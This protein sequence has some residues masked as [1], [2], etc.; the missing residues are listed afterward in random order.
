MARAGALTDLDHALRGRLPPTLAEQVRL[1]NVRDGRIV[2]V[3]SSA[4]WAA[5]LRMEQATLL[6]LARTLGV[7]ARGVTIRIAPLPAAPPEPAAGPALSAAAARHLRAA[8]AASRDPQ[9][10]AQLLAMASLATS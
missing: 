9:L 4:A 6:R 1:G 5:R 2:F 8:A 10:R 7:D 3:A